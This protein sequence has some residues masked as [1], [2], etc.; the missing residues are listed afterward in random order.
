MA[1]TDTKNYGIKNKKILFIYSCNQDTLFLYQHIALINQMV[2]KLKDNNQIFLLST[3][4][5][6][7]FAI[8]DDAKCITNK[9]NV[10]TII[11]TIKQYNIDI[12]IPFDRDKKEINHIVEKTK[13]INFFNSYY[14]YNNNNLFKSLAKKNGFLIKNLSLEERQQYKAIN[15]S[16]INDEFGNQILL[17]TFESS[18]IDDKKLFCNYLN[19]DVKLKKN[20]KMLIKTFSRGLKIKNFPYNIK[21]FIKNQNEIFF[22]SITYGLSEEVIFAIQ[23]SQTNIGQMMLSIHCRQAI[24]ETKNYK[25]VSWT[26]NYLNLLRSYYSFNVINYSGKKYDATN[27]RILEND[28]LFYLLHQKNNQLSIF[29]KKYKIKILQKKQILDNEEYI[30]VMICSN[31]LL[32]SSNNILFAKICNL[33]KQETSKKIILLTEVMSPLINLINYDI[34]I[35]CVDFN[36]L[37]LQEVLDIFKIKMAYIIATEDTN[38]VMNYFIKKKIKLLSV[39]NKNTQ[40]EISL[41]RDDLNT[42]FNEL[43]ILYSQ[44]IME[45]EYTVIKFCCITDVYKNIYLNT[46]INEKFIGNLNNKIFLYPPK[47]YNY[48]IEE[49]INGIVEKVVDNMQIYG[50]L[51]IDFI[52]SNGNVYLHTINIQQNTL[53]FDLHLLNS[54]KVLL[55]I[56]VKAI[57]GQNIYTLTKQNT[58]DALPAFYQKIKFENLNKQY[59]VIDD[60]TQEKVIKKYKNIVE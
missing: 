25:I 1:K 59:I 8:E 46:I 31:Y 3:F 43:N 12:I 17:D 34:L 22:D 24:F 51:N 53:L 21:I 45:E 40:K 13:V 54:N 10:A 23:N 30:V 41:S 52:Y 33:L 50:L 11:D 16:A 18:I 6:L 47:L 5:N 36:K 20:I 58:P 15:I 35:N 27:Y 57:T 44:N 32:L 37:Y 55:N 2:E 38:I 49:T 29:Q 9:I 28:S 48:D 39:S 19:I 42:V 60:I 26:Y 56:L 7:K 14:S 4:E